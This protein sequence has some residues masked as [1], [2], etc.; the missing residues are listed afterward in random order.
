MHSAM[1]QFQ[2]LLFHWNK[3]RETLKITLKI[4][5]CANVI[6]NIMTEKY[7]PIQIQ[8]VFSKNLPFTWSI[9]V[10]LLTFREI[11]SSGKIRFWSRLVGIAEPC[12]IIR[13]E[14]ERIN[15]VSIIFHVYYFFHSYFEQVPRVKSL[16][17]YLDCRHSSIRRIWNDD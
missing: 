13:R 17:R 7:N 3:F 11:N 12:L 9:R 5:F 4:K 1:D 2:T 14:R 10:N 8:Y 16:F 15:I 6:L